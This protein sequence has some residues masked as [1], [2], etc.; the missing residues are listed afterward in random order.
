MKIIL[1]SG[2]PRTDRATM[3]EVALKRLNLSRKRLDF[4]DFDEISSVM[5][6]IL[7]GKDLTIHQISEMTKQ[8]NDEF[9]RT[10]IKS[11]K[12]C[13]GVLVANC[14]IT[15]NTEFGIFPVLKR[16]FFETFSPELILLIEVLP[17]DVAK[18]TK[19][20]KLVEKHQKIN[21]IYA[22]SYSAMTHSAV[23]RIVIKK[24]KLD[25]AIRTF[26]VLLKSIETE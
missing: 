6:A 2:I 4:V 18:K 15:L 10:V 26:T 25:D 16:D 11:M 20:M 1:V 14:S 12:T 3:V 8:L 17:L 9:E 21:E 24:G 19:E 22:F 13:S 23:D 5:N 7:S